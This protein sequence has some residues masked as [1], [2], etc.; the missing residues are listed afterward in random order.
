M[1]GARF[2]VGARQTLFS[3]DRFLNDRYAVFYD[4]ARDDQRFLFVE[5]VTGGDVAWKLVRGF[6]RIADEQLGR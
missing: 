3:A 4:V 6:D 2:T 1:A 5:T